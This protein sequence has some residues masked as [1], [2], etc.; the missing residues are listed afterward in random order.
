MPALF[1]IAPLYLSSDMRDRV[2]TAVQTISEQEGLLLS[3]IS[4]QEISL[5]SVRIVARAHYRGEDIDRCLD[6]N[7]STVTSTPC[8]EL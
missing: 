4:I 1:A 3:G 6:I 8:E 2:Q 7:L 5:N